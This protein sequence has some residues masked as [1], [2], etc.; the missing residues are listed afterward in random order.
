[1]G[2]RRPGIYN[3]LHGD[4]WKEGPDFYKDTSRDELPGAF[5]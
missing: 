4:N 3:D 2:F 5:V 1:M